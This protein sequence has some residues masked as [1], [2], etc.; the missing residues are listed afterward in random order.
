MTAPD[1]VGFVMSS[2]LPHSINENACEHVEFLSFL[3]SPVSRRLAAVWFRLHSFTKD[4]VVNHGRSP[5]RYDVQGRS[6]VVFPGVV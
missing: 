6:S 4:R 2:L 1:L 3:F 5:P